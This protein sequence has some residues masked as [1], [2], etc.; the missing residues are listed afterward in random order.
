MLTTI[1]VANLGVISEAEIDLGDGLIALTGETGAGKTMVVTAIELL[2]GAKPS[3]SLVRDGAQL[4]VVEG[5]FLD[6]EGTEV[7]VSREIPIQGRAK[8]YIDG[9]LVSATQLAD[10]GEGLLEL[11]SQNLSISLARPTVQLSLVDS[12]AQLDTV[13]RDRLRRKLRELERARDEMNS[14]SLALEKEVER[15][16]FEVSEIEAASLLDL[17]ESEALDAEFEMLSQAEGLREVASLALV[18]LSSDE[19]PAALELLATAS[20]ALSHHRYFSELANQGEAALVQ[21][22]DM[23]SELRRRL[24]AIDEDPERLSVVSSRIRRL[25]ELKRKFGPTIADVVQHLADIRAQLS[26]LD[27]SHETRTRL[28]G[29]IEACTDE[30]QDLNSELRQKRGQAAKR[31]SLSLMEVLTK[32]AFP[33]PNFSVSLGESDDGSPI[34]F[35]FSPNPGSAP[36]PIS[37]SASGGEMSRLMLAISL[38]CRSEVGTL[39]FDE[40]DAGVGGG[41]ALE[42]GKALCELANGRQVIVVTHLAQVAAF[43]DCQ[44]SVSKDIEGNFTQT[45]LQVLN[46]EDRIEEISRMLSGHPDSPV[47][48][49]HA[50]ELI[51]LAYQARTSL[52]RAES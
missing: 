4:A 44:I 32:L 6:E 5:L 20:K 38:I 17:N 21:L 24:E 41:T 40:I 18:A 37:Q 43:A 31:L 13:P 19:V 45:K 2:C 29:E 9:R 12:Y 46:D 8:A 3:S 35:L 26:R 22:Y 15:L 27:F 25:G 28:E 11:F 7:S 51:E 16:R 50:S 30:L 39:I 47:A 23:H 1:K 48:R 52:R 42:V 49:R 34:T 33:S 36:Q 10:L 14:N